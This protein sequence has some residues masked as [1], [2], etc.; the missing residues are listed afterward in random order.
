MVVSIGVN[1]CMS[2]FGDKWRRCRLID[3]HLPNCGL[4]YKVCEIIYSCVINN[5][6]MYISVYIYI[7][8]YI[9]IHTHIQITY[10]IQDFTVSTASS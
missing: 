10:Q 1:R 6:L 3:H 2:I 8:I 9:Y 7:Y 5:V 4:S